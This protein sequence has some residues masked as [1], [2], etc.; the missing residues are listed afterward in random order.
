MKIGEQSI[1]RTATRGTYRCGDNSV[2]AWLGKYW[3]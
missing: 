2:A 3:K 1:E